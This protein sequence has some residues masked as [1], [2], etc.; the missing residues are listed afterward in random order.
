MLAR[1]LSV[2]V[3]AVLGATGCASIPVDP[4]GTLERAAL[5]DLMDSRPSVF[6]DRTEPHPVVE[7]IREA[8]LACP[9]VQDVQVRAREEG[10]VFHA[11]VF[12]LPDAGHT[13]GVDELD[14]VRDAVRRLDWK[15]HDVVIAPVAR[16]PL[17]NLPPQ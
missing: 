11:E 4:K 3:A 14:A 2:A 13:L 16:L 8:V 9:H 7:Q 10:H 12:L 6:D 17:G 15:L 5:S 1:A